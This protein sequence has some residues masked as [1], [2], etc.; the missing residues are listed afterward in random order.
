M[1]ARLLTAYSLMDMN[2][3][4]FLRRVNGYGES[5]RAHAQSTYS[6]TSPLRDT[7]ERGET[8]ILWVCFI[9]GA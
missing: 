4:P 2:S 5:P 9:R 1:R 7:C 6:Q 3:Q 8:W